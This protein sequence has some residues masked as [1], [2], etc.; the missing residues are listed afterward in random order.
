[1]MFRPLIAAIV[2]C[3]SFASAQTAAGTPEPVLAGI[4]IREM[5][6]ADVQK[7]YGPQDAVYGVPPDPYPQGSK[8]HKWGRLNMNL[9]VLT[10]PS[11]KGH[12][13]KAIEVQGEGETQDKP[14][15]KTGRGLKLGAK[16]GDIKKIYGLEPS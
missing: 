3:C 10:E 12:I 9:K 8:L 13:I 14:I 11:R 7:M 16:S 4:N 5:K 2:L 1:M 6:I 15:N